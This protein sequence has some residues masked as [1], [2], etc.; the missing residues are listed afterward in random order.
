V[1]AERA[2]EPRSPATSRFAT[3]ALAAA[4]DSV[5]CSK[6]SS[7][8]DA[9]YRSVYDL[10]QCWHAAVN[11]LLERVGGVEKTRGCS[12]LLQVGRVSW[13]PSTADT[14]FAA[15]QH[16]LVQL[17]KSTQTCISRT[18]LHVCMQPEL[19]RV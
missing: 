15:A 7:S 1:S 12:W 14:L 17:A 4:K 9:F 6:R 3:D 13:S 19:T 8:T 2:S 16:S 11:D 5:C 18:A 10:F